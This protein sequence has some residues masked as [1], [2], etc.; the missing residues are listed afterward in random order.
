MKNITRFGLASTVLSSFG[1]GIHTGMFF[2]PKVLTIETPQQITVNRV[3]DGDSI[4]ASREGKE[5]QIRL[6]CIDAPELKQSPFGQMS[7]NYAERL[8]NKEVS[9]QPLGV[10]S[11]GRIVGDVTTDGASLSV[12]MVQE[13]LAAVYQPYLKI[14]PDI[15]EPLKFH[16]KTAKSYKKGVWSDPKFEFPWLYRRRLRQTQNE[17]VAPKDIV[18]NTYQCSA[19]TSQ[20]EA[21]ELL[22]KYPNDP[23]NLDQ[24]NNKIACEFLP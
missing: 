18:K 11:Y 15:A 17:F 1:V 19:F 5:F 12:L 14:C 8:L 23:Y 20:K 21:Q 2:T 10:D 4:V 24:N 16:E 6:A 3:I 13:G 22:N 7:K 9:F